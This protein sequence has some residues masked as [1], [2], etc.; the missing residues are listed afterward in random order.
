MSV[1]PKRS[2]FSDRREDSGVGGKVAKTESAPSW[3]KQSSGLDALPSSGSNNS[4]ALMPL[5]GGLLPKADKPKLTKEER[6]ALRK[7]KW[8][9]DN[10][11]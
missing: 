10:V 7:K 4:L 9:T 6:R 5:S 1:A 8:S 2:R 11:R 3:M